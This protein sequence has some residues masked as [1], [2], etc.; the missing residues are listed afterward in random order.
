MDKLY[1]MSD[2]KECTEYFYV[3]G[4]SIFSSLFEIPDEVA[5][6]VL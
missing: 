5:G 6:L 2:K 3:L 4:K 1:E